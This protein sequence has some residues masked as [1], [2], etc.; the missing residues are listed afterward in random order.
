MKKQHKIQL[1]KPCNEDWDNMSKTER[2]K[3][4][5]VCKKDVIDFTNYTDDELIKTLKKEKIECARLKANQL[6]RV[7][8]SSKKKLKFSLGLMSLAS[9]FTPVFAQQVEVTDE[10]ISNTISEKTIITIKGKV[11]NQGLPLPGVIIKIKNS[12]KETMTDF[13]GLFKLKVDLSKDFFIEI[14]SLGFVSDSIPLN[15]KTKFINVE[16]KE[17][18]D[19]PDEVIV[20]G[21]IGFCTFKSR[22]HSANYKKP[23]S[24]KER[25][26]HH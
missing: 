5:A 15:K 24:I 10:S 23:G 17:N 26:R 11:I 3:H 14:S 6:N 9:F 7:L 21:G 19:L 22:Y 8:K 12:G 18:L 1:T 13:D 2:G 16:L 4:C 25:R 20:A